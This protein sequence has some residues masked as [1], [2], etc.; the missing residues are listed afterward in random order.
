MVASRVQLRKFVTNTLILRQDDLPR[1]IYF[2]KTGRIKVLRKVEFKIPENQKQAE[3]IQDLIRDPSLDEY[4]EGKVESKLL[5]ID[6]L[7]C[8]DLFAEYASILREPI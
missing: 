1:S 7:S 8:G 6:E 4:G 5:E 3:S 2:V